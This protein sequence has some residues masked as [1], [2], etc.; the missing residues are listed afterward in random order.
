M[1]MKVET[2][3][4]EIRAESTDVELRS[5]VAILR[6]VDDLLEFDRDYVAK[7]KPRG[8]SLPGK[9]L[10][11][12]VFLLKDMPS[13]HGTT[14]PATDS[15]EARGSA[16]IKEGDIVEIV[17]DQRKGET[18]IE[19]ERYYLYKEGVL[20]EISKPEVKEI[21]EKRD[22]KDSNGASI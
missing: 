14:D 12:L 16:K 2:E 19:N 22:Q 13:R 11:F 6:G 1:G 5:H 10:H 20:E 3:K 17:E 21:L 9:F 18:K 7:Q 15:W 8:E 4:G